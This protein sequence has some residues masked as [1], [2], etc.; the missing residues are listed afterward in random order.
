MDE[1]E[2][3]VLAQVIKRPELFSL[4][5]NSKGLFKSEKSR[6][7][8]NALE[9]LISKDNSHIDEFLLAET[10]GLKVEEILSLPDG[11]HR[12]PEE[13]FIEHLH[14]LE[15][16]NFAEEFFRES[17]K[18]KNLWLKNIEPDFNPI[19][20]ITEKI[21]QASAVQEKELYSLD[22]IERKEVHWLWPERFPLGKLS[23][24][25]GDPGIGK[26]YF[27]INVAASITTG[28]AWPD[29]LTA[30]PKGTVLL[31]NCEDGPGDTI[32][33]RAEDCGADCSKITILNANV[34]LSLEVERLD[35]ILRKMKDCRLV[36]I[37]PI[38]AH[39]GDFDTDKM[40]IRSALNPLALL[41]EKYNVANLMI[42]HLNKS[43]TLKA[44]YR[45][46]G[47][48]GFI[49]A[50]RSVY[51]IARDEEDKDRRLF[52]PLKANLAVDAKT[53]A[54]RIINKAIIFENL[55]VEVDA[56]AALSKEAAEESSCLRDAIEFLEMELADG[57]V[58]STDL[59]KRAAENEIS[60]RTLKRAK[61]KLAC[62]SSKKTG[63][64]FWRL[65]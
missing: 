23:L 45:V 61:K 33:P 40:R 16:R 31:L 43:E 56:E 39:L 27:S 35:S 20:E 4:I 48:V 47:S 3:L 14:R 60:I 18:Q 9:S 12:I 37:D 7:V 1:K 51:A 8:F 58:L 19:L 42:S 64:W 34:D 17:E 63:Q 5:Q 54:W 62:I 29:T 22:G 52:I 25:V 30:A 41:A 50:A 36:I 44:L 57:P 2:R 26:S 10:S 6:R 32:K 49:A 13:N 38:T 65:G 24:L 21:K 55:P 59:L 28:R 15:R 11:V 53:L 46:T